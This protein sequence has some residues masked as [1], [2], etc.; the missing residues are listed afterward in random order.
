MY[1]EEIRNSTS[2]FTDK[3]ASQI[4]THQNAA[5][6][7]ADPSAL[8]A[9][10][11]NYSLGRDITTDTL[12][13]TPEATGDYIAIGYLKKGADI[14]WHNTEILVDSDAAAFT[15]EIGLLDEEG[16]F[17][18]KA[19][20]GT[21]T[22]FVGTATIPEPHSAILDRPTWVV[23]KITGTPPTSGNLSFYLQYIALA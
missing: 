17:T 15:C 22:G 16:V 20:M 1:L 19:T 14:L 12:L 4:A 2:F 18:L 5:M 3:G 8:L 11:F 23:A 21:P 10:K 7:Q 13:D 9:K 6:A